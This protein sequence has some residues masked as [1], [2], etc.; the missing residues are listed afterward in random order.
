MTSASDPI[1]DAIHKGRSGIH[2]VLRVTASL[3]RADTGTIL[4]ESRVR[5]YP[6]HSRRAIFPRSMGA[7][8]SRPRAVR[9]TPLR[10]AR[11]FDFDIRLLEEF[12]QRE[13]TN[14]NTACAKLLVQSS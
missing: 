13:A 10:A 2:D 7:Y 11:P 8:G 4:T 3:V 12:L 14:P 9:R 6:A 5:V 1:R